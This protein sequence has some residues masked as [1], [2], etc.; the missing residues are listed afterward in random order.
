MILDTVG[1]FCEYSSRRLTSHDSSGKV[2]FFGRL[3]ALVF[4]RPSAYET[5]TIVLQTAFWKAFPNQS[6]R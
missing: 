1:S 3:V 6:K 5:A 2:D 4:H